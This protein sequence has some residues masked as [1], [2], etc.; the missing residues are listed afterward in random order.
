MI[1]FHC[2]LLL[3]AVVIPDACSIVYLFIDISEISKR[4][5][6]CTSIINIMFN[7]KRKLR[8]CPVNVRYSGVITK[9]KIINF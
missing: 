1:H 9:I 7:I 4:R 2:H 3:K 8:K 5:S 6:K